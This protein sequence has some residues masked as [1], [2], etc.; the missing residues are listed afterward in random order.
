[1]LL[2]PPPSLLG[3]FPRGQCVQFDKCN[4]SILEDFS[5]ENDNSSY[6]EDN[7]N[8]FES[9]NVTVRRGL[10]DGNNSPSG[11]GVM[12]ECG[13]KAHAYM[14]SGLVENV[15]SVHQGNG[16]CTE[17]PTVSSSSLHLSPC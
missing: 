10:I 12:Y 8:V 11:D 15:D 4:N 5:C 14:T 7:V 9:N 17:E 13:D 3:P 2:P 16:L 1:M 6:T